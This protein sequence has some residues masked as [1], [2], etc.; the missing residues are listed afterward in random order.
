MIRNEADIIIPFLNQ[1]FTFFD[2]IFL[3]DVQSTDGTREIID[4]YKH[5]ND[6]EN[7][8]HIYN[9][10][11]QEKYQ[12]AISN[13]LSR[14][15]FRQGAMWCFFLD[16]DEFIALNNAETLRDKLQTLKSDVVNLPWI[17]LVP[18]R[19]GSFCEF[20]IKQHFFYST[21]QHPMAKVAI[22]T[23]FAL[24]YPDYHIDEGNHSISKSRG[25]LPE[26]PTNLC[27]LL[28]IPVRSSERFHYKLIS[29]S[30]LLQTKEGVTPLEGLH[31]KDML[32]RIGGTEPDSALLC[33]IAAGYSTNDPGRN[34]KRMVNISKWPTMSMPNYLNVN[35]EQLNLS[36]PLEDVIQRDQKTQWITLVHSDSMPI[37]SIL[38]DHEI[39]IMD[40]PIMGSKP[41]QNQ[42]QSLPEWNDCQEQGNI[43]NEQKLLDSIRA[44]CDVITSIPLKDPDGIAPVLFILFSLERPKRFVSI[45]RGDSSP[46]E[47]ACVAKQN[48]FTSTECIAIDNWLEIG[49]NK[50]LSLQHFSMDMMNTARQHDQYYYRGGFFDAIKFFDNSSIDMINVNCSLLSNEGVEAI[51]N[52]L[53]QKLTRN[54]VVVLTNL[55]KSVGISQTTFGTLEFHNILSENQ[56]GVVFKSGV[57]ILCLGTRPS[58][59]QS[60]VNL[61][62]NDANSFS[63]RFLKNVFEIIGDLSSNFYYK[64]LQISQNHIKEVAPNRKPFS[65]RIHD[66]LRNIV[67]NSKYRSVLH[68]KAVLIKKRLRHARNYVRTIAS[69]CW[70]FPNVHFV[71]YDE[72]SDIIINKKELHKSIRLVIP[73]RGCS[74]WLE[75]FLDAYKEFGLK[76][77]YAIDQGCE[78][79]T[80][81]ILRDRNID[82]IFIDV[83]QLGNGESIMPFLSQEIKEDYIFRLDD[84]EFPSMKLLDFVNSIPDSGYAFVQSWWLPRYEI[85]LIDDR[86]AS[87]HPNHFRTKVGGKIYENLHGGRFFRH[88]DVVYDKVGPH[89]GNFI[90]NFVSHAPEKALIFHL[91]YLVRS[92]EERLAKIRAVEARFPGSGWIFANHMIPEFAPRELLHAKDFQAGE[93]SFLVERIMKNVYHN[94]K[95]LTLSPEEILLIQGDRLY[96]NMVHHHY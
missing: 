48:L 23:K 51:L 83:A 79:E 47:I 87:C 75:I 81:R 68:P 55:H 70:K 49:E 74:K 15:A 4:A 3:V 56:S 80:L 72:S 50:F 7:K 35:P 88:K 21:S 22:S 34:E 37:G 62:K 19:F 13:M 12:S 73:T 32:N 14:Y 57:G 63:S 93:I 20:D 36:R 40:Q 10:R 67:I 86:L 54:A 76:P 43:F 38:E 91:D 31:V 90:S 78:P 77:T 94:S 27:S 58:T 64:Y 28:H 41:V 89:H 59:I 45:T 46:Y 52:A 18:K 65:E 33:S 1:I 24:T 66:T 84:D 39:K 26:E 29:A 71:K 8:L 2:E 61:L 69:H 6:F 42:F 95:N 85:A 96:Q 44:T 17:N 16:A 30:R 25:A 82:I 5:K 53:S 92:P 60:F 11:T 9:C